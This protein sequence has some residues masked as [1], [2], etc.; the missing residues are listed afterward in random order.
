MQ[1]V[2]GVLDRVKQV[3]VPVTKR[4][5][6]PTVSLKQWEQILPR[7]FAEP[8]SKGVPVK[9]LDRWAQRELEPHDSSA[10]TGV[11]DSRWTLEGW[12]YVMRP[13]E[14]F[15]VWWNSGTETESTFWI[16]V[17]ITEAPFPW[18]NLEV[19]VFLAGALS[20]SI[21]E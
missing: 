4:C 16:D 6:D 19:I 21:E 10:E 20:L 1:D 18:E 13:E 17:Q 3:M 15:W 7:W 14:R 8:L 5:A 2:H 12:L 9:K 11:S